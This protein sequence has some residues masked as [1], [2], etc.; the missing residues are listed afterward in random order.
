MPTY[1][2]RFV[3]SGKTDL[4][5]EASGFLLKHDKILELTAQSDGHVIAVIPLDQVLFIKEEKP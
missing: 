5:L 4:V 2:V 1:R 3:G